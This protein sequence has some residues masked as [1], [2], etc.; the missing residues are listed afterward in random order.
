MATACSVCE[1][2]DFIG[3]GEA[4]FC[5]ACGHSKDQHGQPACPSCGDVVLA[6]ARFCGACGSEL[7]ALSDESQETHHVP[8]RQRTSAASTHGQGLQMRRWFYVGAPAAM[9][10]VALTFFLAAV[11]EEFF[12]PDE[13]DNGAGELVLTCSRF[14]GMNQSAWQQET[15]LSWV[16]AEWERALSYC[17]APGVLRTDFVTIK[18]GR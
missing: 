10:L 4:R 3:T 15:G 9:G 14:M 11:K 13:S 12:Q 5:S 18:R 16:G 8:G 17:M 2:S 7:A 6:T 1:C